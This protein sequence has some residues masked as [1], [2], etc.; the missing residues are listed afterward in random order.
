MRRPRPDLD[1][2]LDVAGR[3]GLARRAEHARRA[4]AH[5]LPDADHLRRLLAD[6]ASDWR[7]VLHR[8]RELL[9]RSRAP[10]R[11]RARPRRRARR[12]RRARDGQS[13][14][15]PPASSSSRRHAPA[16]A[17]AL[18]RL[19]R[20]ALRARSP[21]TTRSPPRTE[22]A[23]G[24][25]LARRR[26]RRRRRRCARRRSHGRAP[27]LA[28]ARG[29]REQAFATALA[30]IEAPRRRARR[31]TGAPAWSRAAARRPRRSRAVAAVDFAEHLDD[32]ERRGA[33]R[34]RSRP[35]PARRM[36]DG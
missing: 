32:D 31:R 20:G 26:A 24:G 33:W 9:T 10:P 34:R 25:P 14:A 30:E 1:D 27:R 19:A 16:S 12:R 2:A 21:T 18:A 8:H 22:L 11:G 6:L 28:A 29:G 13:T 4:A 3:A 5:G 23:D 17:A 35:R 15:R 7:D 36:A